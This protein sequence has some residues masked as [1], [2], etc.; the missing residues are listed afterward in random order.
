MDAVDG[1]LILFGGFDECFDIASGC[2]HT[3]YNEV[4]QYQT[5]FNTWFKANPTSSTGSQPDPRAFIAAD[6]YVLTDSVI[7]FG[8]G[9]YN[10]DVS[11]FQFYNDVWQYFP[12]T[13]TFVKRIPTN[14]GPSTRLGPE[15][16]IL[17][18]NAYVFAGIDSTFTYKNDLWKYNLLTNTWTLLTPNGASGSPGPRYSPQMQLRV[19]PS[20]KHII[21]Y[22]GNA[23][24]TGSG[25]QN[26]DTWIYHINTNTWENTTAVPGNNVGRTHG[27]SA[28]YNDKFI[29]AL[30]DKKNDTIACR[31][32]EA[33]GGQLPTST[34]WYLNFRDRNDP[35]FDYEQAST[36]RAP[37]LKRIAYCQF[38]KKLWIWGGFDFVCPCG[39]NNGT[40]QWNTDMFTLDLADLT[41]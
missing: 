38:Q 41:D 14:V 5:D 40:A 10:V 2:N 26:N 32:N 27:A 31:T 22:G 23:P 34:T 28:F 3:F 36:Q 21:V 37:R 6:H 33:S 29:I 4:W 19:T 8:G 16:V 17:E 12:A 25:N 15:M 30:G 24:P 7:Y 35:N 20:V 13:D 18:H 11:F 39:I 1:K 9:R